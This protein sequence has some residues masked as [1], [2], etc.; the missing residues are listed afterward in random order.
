MNQ[1]ELKA[2]IMKLLGKPVVTEAAG[3]LEMAENQYTK[4]PSGL[5]VP[6]GQ[7]PPP[8]QWD[9]DK[10]KFTVHKKIG[11]SGITE[12]ALLKLAKDMAETVDAELKQE[13][14]KKL[15]EYSIKD[16]ELT[17]HLM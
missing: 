11:Y 5:L 17:K 13:M 15:E 3:I 10:N 1:Q 9:P 6:K 7:S 12:E 2:K 14:E 4:L 8:A 16:I